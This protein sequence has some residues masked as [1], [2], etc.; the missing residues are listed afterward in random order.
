[1]I[2]HCHPSSDDQHVATATAYQSLLFS[3]CLHSSSSPMAASH[4]LLWKWK[5]CTQ[6]YW[7]FS[8]CQRVKVGRV[9]RRSHLCDLQGQ[10]SQKF[11][12]ALSKINSTKCLH[13][14][15]IWVWSKFFCY[16]VCQSGCHLYCVFH[17]DQV[18]KWSCDSLG[19]RLYQLL[20]MA[21]MRDDAIH[22]NSASNAGLWLKF[23]R[24]SI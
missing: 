5:S 22:R 17:L 15:I 12:R 1:M 13:Y 2:D 4:I 21:T 23:L 16:T 20:A 18:Q 3:S 11:D 8:N 6:H 7:K 9:Q 19:M 24:V 10:R 14:T